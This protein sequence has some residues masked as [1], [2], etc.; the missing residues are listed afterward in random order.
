MLHM[1]GNKSTS[2]YVC[3]ANFSGLLIEQKFHCFS[4]RDECN[5]GRVQVASSTWHLAD[6]SCHLDRS[7]EP[8]ACLSAIHL[9]ALRPAKHMPTTFEYPYQFKESSSGNQLE[10]RADEEGR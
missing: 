6:A 4:F 3:P 7:A 10:C 5:S 1:N 8:S 2:F 9:R